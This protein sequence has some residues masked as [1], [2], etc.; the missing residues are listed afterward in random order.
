V[1]VKTRQRL[2]AAAG[3]AG[4]A[5]Q[6]IALDAQQ[7]IFRTR[8]DLV[9]VDATVIGADG[10]SIDGLTAG[11]FALKVDGEPRRV[12]SAHY[13]A[14]APLEA[15]S[16]LLDARHF[17]SNETDEGRLIV[18]AVDQAHIRQLEG[19]PAL[20]AAAGFLDQLDS[21][22]HVAV[23]SLNRTADLAFTRDHAALK[24]RLER[25]TG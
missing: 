24:A 7:A 19:R 18:I 22:D 23:T 5:L 17:T 4:L 10:R 15:R 3:V 13:V 8:V 2:A 16:N 25:F 11:D 12:V 9:T 6:A 1:T 20:R 14:F 21:R